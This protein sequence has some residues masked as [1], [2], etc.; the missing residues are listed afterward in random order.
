MER[1]LNETLLWLLYLLSAGAAFLAV[2]RG[3]SRLVPAI[4]AGTLVTIAGWALLYALAG[5]DKRPSFW[6]V[7]LSLNASF[8]LI[9]AAAGAGL[10]FAMN[11]RQPD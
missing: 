8:A 10:A 7:D 5:D 9:F 4:L 11:S 2:Q 1:H 6:Q 3:G